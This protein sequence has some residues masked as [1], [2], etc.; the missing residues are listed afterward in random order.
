MKV[1]KCMIFASLLFL[2]SC[3]AADIFRAQVAERGADAADQTLASA[4]W[5]RCEGATMGAVRRKYNTPEKL[6]AYLAS[7]PQPE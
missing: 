4:E 1:L 7:C 6:E 2:T 5:A 3:Q